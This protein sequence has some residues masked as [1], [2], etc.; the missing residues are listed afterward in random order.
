MKGPQAVSAEDLDRIARFLGP[1]A[2]PVG[3]FRGNGQKSH[4][5][6]LKDD[7]IKLL[8]RRPCTLADVAG[9]LGLESD[10]AEK[11]LKDLIKSGHIQ[12]AV[13]GDQSFF[14]ARLEGGKKLDS[15]FPEIKEKS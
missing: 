1:A 6:N 5:R 9:A 14:H 13:H 4:H 12:T 15:Q 10:Q 2:E 7:V 3:S 8:Q 11:E